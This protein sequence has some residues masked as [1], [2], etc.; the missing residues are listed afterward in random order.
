MLIQPALADYEQVGTSLKRVPQQ[1][2]VCRRARISPERARAFGFLL[3][4]FSNVGR[5]SNS[6]FT[7]GGW[8]LPSTRVKLRLA[9]S[10]DAPAPQRTVSLRWAGTVQF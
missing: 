4:K 5:D 1:L 10:Y 6:R 2:D 3:S 7:S 9:Q 8:Q